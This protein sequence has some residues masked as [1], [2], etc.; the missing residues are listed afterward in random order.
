MLS[1]FRG[2]KLRLS[3]K[4]KGGH[5]EFDFVIVDLN[6]KANIRIESMQTLNRKTGVLAGAVEI[7]QVYVELRG[8]LSTFVQCGGFERVNIKTIHSVALSRPILFTWDRGSPST[9]CH[10]GKKSINTKLLLPSP[11]TIDKLALLWGVSP[12]P[13]LLLLLTL[14]APVA[15]PL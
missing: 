6:L 11:E 8:D 1:V 2:R 15:Q 9:W 14:N 3:G 10:K 5:Q 13:F 7:I 12:L 4:G